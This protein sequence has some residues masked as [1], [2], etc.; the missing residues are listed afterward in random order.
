M[1]DEVKRITRQTLLNKIAG[2]RSTRDQALIAFIYL[3]GCRISE[4][5]GETKH[6]KKRDKETK[7]VIEVKDVIVQPLIKEDIEKI[8]EDIILVKN[9]PC[10]KR[11]AK[12]PTRDIPLKIS[13]DKDFIKIFLE[14]YNKVPNGEALFKIT[15]QR[16]WQI[17]NKELGVFNHFLI[18]Q[19]CTELVRHKQFTDIYLKMFRGWKDT[20][21]AEIY[22][23]LNW[24]D[25]ANKL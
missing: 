11:R 8:G 17:I 19:R 2:I 6:I 21:P 1:Q 25:L 7:E 15:R 22:T 23:H 16:A 5:L 24:Q 4:V 14:H 13:S 3:T 10:L 18:H 20:R 9:V 12:V